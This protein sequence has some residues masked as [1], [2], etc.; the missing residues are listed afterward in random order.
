[1]ATFRHSADIMR[2]NTVITF[3]YLYVAEAYMAMLEMHG[4]CSG[5]PVR[6]HLLSDRAHYIIMN[7]IESKDIWEE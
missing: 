5:P 3:T 4:E 1:M 6:P 7:G 2:D